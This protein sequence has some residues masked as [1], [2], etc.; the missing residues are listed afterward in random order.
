MVFQPGPAFAG[1]DLPAPRHGGREH[2]GGGHRRKDLGGLRPLRDLDPRALCPADPDPEPRG[3]RSQGHRPGRAA[4]RGEGGRGPASGGRLPERFQCGA[5][6]QPGVLHPA[7]AG[8]QHRLGQ[9]PSH[10]YGGEALWGAGGPGGHRLRQYGSGQPGQLSAVRSAGT[11]GVPFLR[12]GGGGE[13]PRGAFP[14]GPVRG[15]QRRHSD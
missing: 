5:G 9:R 13:G 2:Q 1:R 8:R 4:H 15:R 10:R 7:G 14:G 11:G 12:G 3:Q 6:Q